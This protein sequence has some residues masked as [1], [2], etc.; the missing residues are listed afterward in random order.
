MHWL[1][2]VAS[3]PLWLPHRK[4]CITPN[5]VSFYL[6]LLMLL[7]KVAPGSMCI[8]LTCNK[9]RQSLLVLLKDTVFFVQ[10]QKIIEVA[11]QCSKLTSSLSKIHCSSSMHS[12]NTTFS[13]HVN[14]AAHR[15]CIVYEAFSNYSIL[16]KSTPLI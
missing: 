8:P 12:S 2:Q 16:F 14:H 4:Y 13:F 3:H 11:R 7:S 9:R 5:I 10:L 1:L 6:F 15:H